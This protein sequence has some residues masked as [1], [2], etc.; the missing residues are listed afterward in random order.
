MHA[1]QRPIATLLLS[2]WFAMPLSS[3]AQAPTDEEEPGGSVGQCTKRL[4]QEFGKEQLQWRAVVYGQLPAEELNVGAVRTDNEGNAWF[5][6]TTNSWRSA[7]PGYERTTWSDMQ[8]ERQAYP[9][10]RRGIL[11]AP[12]VLESELLPLVGQSIRA[13]QC[14]LRSICELLVAS[15]GISGGKAAKTTVQPLGCMEEERDTFKEC[16]IGSNGTSAEQAE[17]L[18][19]CLDMR[20]TLLDHELELVK[21]AVGQD[22]GYRVAVVLAGVVDAVITLFQWTLQHTILPA[23]N[24]LQ[25][26]GQI[27]CFLSSCD[28]SFPSS[29]SAGKAFSAPSK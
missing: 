24:L 27:P 26:F 5:R 20:T 1:F 8:M 21:A 13:L 14:R 2:A 15:Q 7:A 9:P 16:Q 29:A 4:Q 12:G 18:S 3:F 11:N 28:L 19:T 22:S 10:P 6:V 25:S 23:V 17:I